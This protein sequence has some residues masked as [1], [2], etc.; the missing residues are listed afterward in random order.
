MMDVLRD[1]L[2]ED[3]LIV[4]DDPIIALDFEDTIL[5]LGV[6]TVRTAGNVTRALQLIDERAPDFA[7]LDIGLVRENSLA[8]AERL[9]TLGIPFAFVSGYDGEAALSG[10][11]SQ[12]PRLPKP[13]TTD[14]LEAMLKRA[15]AGRAAR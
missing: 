12:R 6:K 13:C 1:R 11:F 4:E 14:A 2:P 3:V 7:L 9:E 15:A 5:R 8:V 10:A